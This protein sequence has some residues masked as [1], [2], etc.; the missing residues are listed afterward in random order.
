MAAVKGGNCATSSKNKI[1]DKLYLHLARAVVALRLEGR[2]L[3]NR[4]C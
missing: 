1:G 4:S 2:W 3:R